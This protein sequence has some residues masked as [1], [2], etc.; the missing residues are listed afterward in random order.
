MLEEA[1]ISHMI[2]KIDNY[3]LVHYPTINHLEDG[4]HFPDHRAQ[5]TTLI[6]ENPQA[7]THETLQGKMSVSPQD[8]RGSRPETI[9]VES[10]L[11][12][13]EYFAQGG[14]RQNKS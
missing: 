4:S 12:P 10:K 6:Q 11:M 13:K 14:L 2:H 9:N 1:A 7:M 8:R 5:T 3:P